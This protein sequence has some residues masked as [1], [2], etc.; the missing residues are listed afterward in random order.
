[1]IFYCGFVNIHKVPVFI[2]FV[3]RETQEMLNTS[4][5]QIQRLPEA[6]NDTSKLG[7]LTLKTLTNE[8]LKS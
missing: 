3:D 2:D 1:M 7:T 5:Q 4:T 8:E 6:N